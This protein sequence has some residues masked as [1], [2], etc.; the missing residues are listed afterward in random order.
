MV[1]WLF[2]RFYD[3]EIR[4]EDGVDDF[5]GYDLTEGDPAPLSAQMFDR[6][7]ERPE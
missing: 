7:F 1:K 3:E 4:R 6:E 2:Q 5:G